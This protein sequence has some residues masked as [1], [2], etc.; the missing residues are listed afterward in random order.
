MHSLAL[1]LP[2]AE[3][4]FN[5]FNKLVF[6]EMSLLLPFVVEAPYSTAPRMVRYQGPLIHLPPRSTYLQA[7]MAELTEFGAELSAQL[8]DQHCAELVQSAAT[9][10]GLENQKQFQGIEDLAL[11]L[12]EDV[13][14]MCNDVLAAIC[15]CFPSSWIPA[16][17][18]GMS[19]GDIHRP[20]ADGQKLVAASPKIAHIMS[21]PEQGSFRRH[22]WTITNSP[23][24]SQHPKRKSAIV[25]LSIEDLYYRVETQ[26]TLPLQSSA[27]R[28]SLFMV[29]VE[30]C[31]LGIFWSN[32]EQRQKIYDS[33]ESM[34]GAILEYKNLQ[35]IKTIIQKAYS[36]H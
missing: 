14:L 10:L 26:T 35:V 16:K 34:T 9:L 4:R 8:S 18:L 28:A 22:V 1:S 32:L 11:C 23:L 20:V 19:L 3:S 24:L 33:I 2:L 30:V 13:A 36:T 12:E 7:K 17:R 6:G 15:F 31:P 25:P 29:K 27:G 5:G 21:D